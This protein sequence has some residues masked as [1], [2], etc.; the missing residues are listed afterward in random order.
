MDIGCRPLDMP[1]VLS[2]LHDPIRSNMCPLT[3][4]LLNSFFHHSFFLNSVLSITRYYHDWLLA[5]MGE[6]GWQAAATEGELGV[7]RMA[8]GGYNT[9]L[10]S[11]AGSLVY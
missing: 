9:T 5:N 8:S 10:A 4:L 7:A 6:Q 1:S 11:V 3:R 2:L